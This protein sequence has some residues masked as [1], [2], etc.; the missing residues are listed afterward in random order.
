VTTGNQKVNT[1]SNITSSSSVSQIALPVESNVSSVK[2]NPGEVLAKR[3]CLSTSPLSL[4]VTRTVDI[5]YF[6]VNDNVDLAEID[7]HQ[8][9]HI[10]PASSV[11]T[12]LL[13]AIDHINGLTEIY[14]VMRHRLCLQYIR[15]IKDST[16]ADCIFYYQKKDN[17]PTLFREAFIS[18]MRTDP[19]YVKMLRKRRNIEEDHTL[20]YINSNV[21]VE[22]R[23]YIWNKDESDCALNV[24]DAIVLCSLYKVNV[25][26]W[27]CNGAQNIGEAKRKGEF[28]Y[29]EG[30]DTWILIHN[31]ED[32]APK[33][34]LRDA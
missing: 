32:N 1:T 15:L 18:Q 11:N 26:V 8:S 28:N 20:Q 27:E 10:Q 3:R 12:S 16:K 30:Q 23:E 7:G 5:M 13:E 33:F 21:D 19:E 14:S 22:I 2:L 6:M 9:H 4:Q 31:L 24:M 29:V 25:I 34:F 17:D